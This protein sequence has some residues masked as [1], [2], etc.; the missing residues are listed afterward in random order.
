MAGG[1]AS[2][3]DANDA[4]RHTAWEWRDERHARTTGG[5]VK[6]GK[7]YRTAAEIARQAGAVQN[8]A[9]AVKLVKQTARA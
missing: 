4:R 9:T 3:S 5:I 7:R 8:L 6:Q 1:A 2:A